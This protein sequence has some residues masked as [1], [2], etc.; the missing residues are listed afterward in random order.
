MIRDIIQRN[1]WLKLFSVVLATAIWMEIKSGSTSAPVPTFNPVQDSLQVP[2]QI[3]A[4]PADGRIFQVRPES[5]IISIT[6]ESAILNK[7]RRKDYKAYIDLTDVRREEAPTH[8][9]RLDI[10]QGVTLLKITPQVVS[11][12]KV[13]P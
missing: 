7:Y 3:M 9:V 5:V 13:S 12:E 2:V 4:Q 1:F 8:E 6:G 11:L 10:P